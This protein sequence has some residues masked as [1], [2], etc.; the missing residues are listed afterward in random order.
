MPKTDTNITQVGGVCLE[1]WA[2]H[3]K[4]IRRIYRT[5]IFLRKALRVL[6]N[7]NIGFITMMN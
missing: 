6:W 3:D 5:L 4:S 2:C 1:S 7:M